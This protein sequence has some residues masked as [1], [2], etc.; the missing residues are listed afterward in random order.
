M[1]YGGSAEQKPTEKHLFCKTKTASPGVRRLV[2]K[3]RMAFTALKQQFA[4]TLF[5]AIFLYI[6]SAQ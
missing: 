4:H 1:K 5:F 3:Q 6:S 2:M